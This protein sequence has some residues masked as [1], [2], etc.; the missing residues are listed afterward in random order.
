[1]KLVCI[2]II[3]IILLLNPRQGCW[4]GHSVGT[5]EADACANGYV[6]I[7]QI[8]SIWDRVAGSTKVFFE[9]GA[10]AKSATAAQ[11]C[12]YQSL[13]LAQGVSAGGVASCA[14]LNVECR[15]AF[16]RWGGY[17]TQDL[18]PCSKA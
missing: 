5:R 1:M 12:T 8:H 16:S 4:G 7:R 14:R 3:I 11:F 2:I 6:E 13:D 18:G 17:A 9:S 10:L 15:L